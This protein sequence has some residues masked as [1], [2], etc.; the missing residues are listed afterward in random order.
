M[1]RI[2]YETF[3]NAITGAVYSLHY[4]APFI[5]TV[6][7]LSAL[8]LYGTVVLSWGAILSAAAVLMIVGTP[9]VI[10]VLHIMLRGE[11]PP[12]LHAV[13][14]GR[15]ELDFL[16]FTASTFI[17]GGVIVIF[18]A[19]LGVMMHDYAEFLVAD[20]KPH[21]KYGYGEGVTLVALSFSRGAAAL[22][23]LVAVFLWSHFT[24]TAI[25][26]PAYV[27]GYDL[28][29]AEARSLTQH[30]ILRILAASLFI[31][32]GGVTAATFLPWQ[33]FELWSRAL[34]AGFAVW[35]FLHT[36]LALYTVLYHEYTEGYHMRNS[37]I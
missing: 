36:N 6:S 7:V 21:E 31:N 2:L 20:E 37:R 1:I 15:R 11:T 34:L 33:S 13:R 12:L 9:F 16:V 10:M 35:G 26:I 8:H 28:S 32:I 25:R 29:T 24:R 14:W 22:F 18:V 17:F 4:A 23:F 19:H 30:G 27:D 3:K 5:A